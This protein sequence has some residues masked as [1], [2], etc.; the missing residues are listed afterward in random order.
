[1]EVQLVRI[2]VVLEVLEEV[3]QEVT[4]PHLLAQQE[5]LILVVEVV[6]VA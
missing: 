1:M 5:L 4:V 2:L 3:E 6:V